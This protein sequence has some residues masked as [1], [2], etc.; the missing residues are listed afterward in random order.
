MK[1]KSRSFNYQNVIR[2][3][4]EHFET[5]HVKLILIEKRKNVKGIEYNSKYANLNLVNKLLGCSA[6]RGMRQTFY[7]LSKLGGMTHLI[8]LLFGHVK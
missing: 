8:R 6:T 3:V 4:E 2:N 7:C 5:K 1:I